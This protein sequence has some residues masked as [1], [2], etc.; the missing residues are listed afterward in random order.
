MSRFKT[1]RRKNNGTR[2]RKS[3]KRNHSTR[4]KRTTTKT[5]KKL[6]RVF[7]A[8]ACGPKSSD[9]TNDY[10]CYVDNSLRYLQKLWNQANISSPIYYTNPIK[11]H[12]SLA[13]KLKHAC[14]T[15]RCWIKHLEKNS[16]RGGKSQLSDDFKPIYPTEWKSNPTQWLSNLDI[17]RVMSQYEKA[18]KCFEFI[19]P[20][21]INFDTSIRK[22]DT[23]VCTKMCTF[24]LAHQISKN[25]N[26]IG[27]IFNTDPHYKSGEH[28][29]SLFINIKKREIFF[30]DSV[31]NKMPNE[32]AT[33][34]TRVCKQGRQ[35]SP[36]IIF[37]V[38]SNEGIEHQRKNTECGMY[39]LFFIIH[40]LIDKLTPTYIK[41]HVFTDAYIQT[42]RKK[43]F[44]YEKITTSRR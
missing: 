24:N 32:V 41:T 33:F 7:N 31:G 11:I 15:E 12:Q 20:T 35:L 3:A 21:P 42:F 25:K 38:D 6:R 17:G 5:K 23:C 13:A 19:G 18:Y 27:I 9:Q 29:I 16:S 34:I 43:L 30:Y 8:N 26:K 40:M 28:W 44:N 36:P 37:N 22:N 2:K 1:R 14:K 10:T 4:R 39:S